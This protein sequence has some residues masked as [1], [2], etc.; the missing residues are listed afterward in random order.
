MGA[1]D[2]VRSVSAAL[3]ASTALAPPASAQTAVPAPFRSIDENGVDLVT[4]QFTFALT[5]G[6][7]GSG[8][9]TLAM[10]RYFNESGWRD[11]VSGDLRLIPE[12]TSQAVQITFG[13]ISEKFITTGSGWVAAKAN[14]ATLID[15]GDGSYVYT[16]SDGTRIDYTPVFLADGFGDPDDLISNPGAYCSSSNALQCSLPETV[17]APS[18]LKINLKWRVRRYCP[19]GPSGEPVCSIYY[20][21]TS[22]SNSANYKMSLTYANNDTSSAEP[23]ADWYKRTSVSF[24]NL[25]A[26]LP[27]GSSVSYAYPAFDQTE[28]TDAGQCFRQDSLARPQGG[29]TC[30]AASG[31]RASV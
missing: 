15:N 10:Q 7:I 20:R 19:L 28:V 21:L 23:V 18:G 9:G 31:K 13:D 25:A 16:A 5:E 1:I 22:V 4:G 29:E 3:L 2:V 8:T 14:G 17:T 11:N 6:S 30:S 27:N 26:S 24:T 12:G